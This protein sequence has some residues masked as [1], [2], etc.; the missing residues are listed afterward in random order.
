MPILI[1]DKLFCSESLLLYISKAALKRLEINMKQRSI[2]L[3]KK[4]H[5]LTVIVAMLYNGHLMV[6]TAGFVLFR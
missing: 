2:S 6:G 1:S 5:N 4:V 3:E